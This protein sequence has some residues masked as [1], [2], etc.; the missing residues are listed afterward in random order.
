MMVKTVFHSRSIISFTCSW[1][2]KKYF[3][4]LTT[5][6]VG[7]E[8]GWLSDGDW[9]IDCRIEILLMCPQMMIQCKQW[10]IRRHPS[11]RAGEEH[12]FE[13]HPLEN[14]S[15][16]C[17]HIWGRL[18]WRNNNIIIVMIT[19]F[20]CIHFIP[21]PVIRR[22]PEITTQ[23][24]LDY[25]ILWWLFRTDDGGFW[26]VQQDCKINNFVMWV[27]QSKLKVTELF[28]HSSRAILSHLLRK[29]K[30][31][32]NLPEI[33]VERDVTWFSFEVY[34][35]KIPEPSIVLMS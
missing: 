5:K 4:K 15:G 23:I 16:I 22:D 10:N 12:A 3:H 19:S 20:F 9:L 18:H 25:C 29:V 21:N 35:K 7:E 30:E 11:E 1:V 28:Q 8:L 6:N 27:V 26:Q 2:T 13:G 31:D 33:I 24:G 32:K 34:A 14:G 17:P